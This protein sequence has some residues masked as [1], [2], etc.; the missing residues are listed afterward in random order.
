[1]SYFSERDEGEQPRNREQ[2]GGSAWGGFQA[3]IRA[4][5]E[6]GSFGASYP[7]SCRDGRGPIG[8][9][10]NSFWQAMQAEI[11]RLSERPWYPSIDGGLPNTL[12]MLDLLEFCW[13]CIG[14][15]VRRDYHNHFGH[16]HLAYDVEAGRAEF[17]E[18]VNRILRRNALAYELTAAGQI[19]RLAP[20]VLRESLVSSHYRTPDAELNRM[21]ATARRKFLSADEAVRREA[22]EALWD[23]WERIKTLGPGADKKTQASAML[24]RSSGPSSPK[25]RDALEQEAHELTRIGNGLQ[26]RHTEITQE[27]LSQSEHVDYLFQRLFGLILLL[28]RKS[29][30]V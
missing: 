5:V 15:P 25:F 2:I 10:E 24:D 19:E 8:T 29:D 9:N 11:P 3:L 30:W 17:V 27:R 7:E 22:L 26:I 6:D 21:L 28:L 16:Y 14:K 20:P 12:D 1:M 13:R 4:R 18:A 23:A